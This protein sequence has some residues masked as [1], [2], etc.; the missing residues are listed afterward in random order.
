M[1]TTS[2]E[3]SVKKRTVRF[4]AASRQ[5]TDPHSTSARGLSGVALVPGAP[6]LRSVKSD[7]TRNMAG[8]EDTEEDKKQMKAGSSVSKSVRLVETQ[9]RPLS[10]AASSSVRRETRGSVVWAEHTPGRDF[11]PG[12]QAQLARSIA[13]SMEASNK[14]EE[15]TGPDAHASSH[16]DASS[17]KK[18]LHQPFFVAVVAAGL[19]AK[20]FMRTVLALLTFKMGVWSL[21]AL[22]VLAGALMVFDLFSPQILDNGASTRFYCPGAAPTQRQRVASIVG[23]A[24]GDAREGRKVVR[25]AIP[26]LV[27]KPRLKTI[28]AFGGGPWDSPRGDMYLLKGY[29]VSDGLAET[30]VDSAKKDHSPYTACTYDEKA[31]LILSKVTGAY[32]YVDIFVTVVTRLEAV[33]TVLQYSSSWTT[34]SAK[35]MDEIHSLAAKNCAYEVLWHALGH[36]YRWSR[37]AF[38]IARGREKEQKDADIHAVTGTRGTDVVT[39]SISS[40]VLREHL[41][42]FLCAP[43]RTGWI[44]LLSGAIG[45]VVF[46]VPGT[47][48]LG[49]FMRRT[50]AYRLRTTV[51]VLGIIITG[52]ALAFHQL[53]S[54][55]LLVYL[56][57]VGLVYLANRIAVRMKMTYSIREFRAR[58]LENGGRGPKSVVVAFATPEDMPPSNGKWIR[59]RIPDLPSMKE[60]RGGELEW[61]SYS[62][63]SFEVVLNEIQ[64]IPRSVE[65]WKEV[66]DSL[67]LERKLARSSDEDEGGVDLSIGHLSCREDPTF[68]DQRNPLYFSPHERA[69]LQVA[70]SSFE[71]KPE[72][73]QPNGAK[74]P[75]NCTATLRVGS[76]TTLPTVMGTAAVP[77]VYLGNLTFALR[78]H[79]HMV[80]ASKASGS[81]G[82]YFTEQRA[83]QWLR[84]EVWPKLQEASQSFAFAGGATQE[85]PDFIAPTVPSPEVSNLPISSPK[86]Y[87]DG[88]SL[89]RKHENVLPKSQSYQPLSPKGVE[90]NLA[91]HSILR[92]QSYQNRLC[93]VES[94]I[95]SEEEKKALRIVQEATVQN[96]L[97]EVESPIMSEEEKKA[98]RT[99]GGSGSI[100]RS[101]SQNRLCEVESPLRT[102]GGSGQWSGDDDSHWMTKFDVD[103][104]CPHVAG[105]DSTETPHS[106]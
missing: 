79:F 104:E 20:S 54:Q 100:L 16:T 34:Q 76:G 56:V 7:P 85:F 21:D 93:E 8:S 9:Q 1:A 13:S 105:N 35:T 78:A 45:M 69:V 62:L 18:S 88:V 4:W 26:D 47:T 95:M 52:F 89:S 59:V 2:N 53:S 83:E 72:E 66:M 25:R 15:A 64:W 71:P 29:N 65:V 23:S 48:S 38:V 49:Q 73:M 5:F 40:E 90:S 27:G 30:L 102:R 81:H 77:R 99:R 32:L 17:C 6:Q 3:S 101:S 92:S 14:A 36:V 31:A 22:R 28:R 82:A 67:V 74:P 91:M 24:H 63:A 33:S 39:S 51:H 96:R 60:R 10:E 55:R 61:H 12:V 70:S 94:P 50:L 57:L 75:S 84:D 19:L 42:V 86:E 87:A 41:L 97:C 80:D 37:Q 46:A 44:A 58:R 106:V 98:L 43:A 11:C 103:D 68:E